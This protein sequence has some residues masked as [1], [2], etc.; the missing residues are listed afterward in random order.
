[1]EQTC[2]C[3]GKQFREGGQESDCLWTDPFRRRRF[4]VKRD[5]WVSQ[6]HQVALLTALVLVRKGLACVGVAFGFFIMI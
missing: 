5:Q 6:S 3:S 1:M 2:A 4:G